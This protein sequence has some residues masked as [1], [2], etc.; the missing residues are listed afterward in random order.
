[1]T[2]NELV[3]ILKSPTSKLLFFGG[4]LIAG[5][6]IAVSFVT[7][8]DGENAVVTKRELTD[9]EKEP[10]TIQTNTKP[11]VLKKRRSDQPEQP[12]APP[13]IGDEKSASASAPAVKEEEKKPEPVSAASAEK[14]AE[15]KD[16][17]APAGRRDGYRGGNFGGRARTPE[18]E[19]S[20]PHIFVLS[21]AGQDQSEDNVFLSETY[22]S[23]GRLLDCKLVNTLES[24]IPNTPL[25]AVVIEDLWWTNAQGEKKLIIPAGT[26]VHGKIGSCV[27][28]RMMCSGNFILVWQITSGQVGMELQLQGTVLEKSN[29]P[30]SKDRATITDM[31]A[32]IP[33]RV[34]NNQNLNEM[35]QYSM[36]FA[37]G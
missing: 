35:L 37:M 16:P 6:F 25:I 19:K 9:K 8:D 2:A 21:A 1:M 15:K 36:A 17:S 34:M 14:Q 26:E 12:S 3:A 31:S 11:Y 24:N 33:G 23:F 27:R 4:L 20:V 13:V 32:G 7:R 10:I 30:G 28:N 22:A 18:P 29:Q 5:A